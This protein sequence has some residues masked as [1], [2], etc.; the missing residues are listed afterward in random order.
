MRNLSE[1]HLNNVTVTYYFAV[2]VD[3][4]STTQVSDTIVVSVVTVVVSVVVSVEQEAIMTTKP[5]IRSF[6]MLQK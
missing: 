2:P 3:T 4:E 5:R 1:P 6:F